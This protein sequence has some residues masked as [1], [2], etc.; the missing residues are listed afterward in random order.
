[1]YF[2]PFISSM[3]IRNRPYAGHYEEGCFSKQN[4]LRS[5]KSK[6]NTKYFAN[7]KKTSFENDAF[8]RKK[9]SGGELIVPTMATNWHVGS[10]GVGGN[11]KVALGADGGETLPVTSPS[12]NVPPQVGCPSFG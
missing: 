4:E 2:F 6:E 7:V 8:K 11:E 5:R 10:K 9:G 1:M 12:S 3:F